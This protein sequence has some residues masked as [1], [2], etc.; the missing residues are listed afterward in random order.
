[1]ESL[2]RK[3]FSERFIKIASEEQNTIV[4]A[5]IINIKNTM[6][7]TVRMSLKAVQPLVNEEKCSRLRN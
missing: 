6:R 2:K 7:V 3:K 1:M 5:I 4:S